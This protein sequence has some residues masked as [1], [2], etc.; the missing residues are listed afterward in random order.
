MN[1][2]SKRNLLKTKKKKL[3]ENKKKHDNVIKLIKNTILSLLLI[4]TRLKEQEII[5]IYLDIM[6]KKK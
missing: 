1:K 5:K 4:S 2:E 3:L 6:L